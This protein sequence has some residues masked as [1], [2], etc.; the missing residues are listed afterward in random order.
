MSE[1]S[2]LPDQPMGVPVYDDGRLAVRYQRRLAHPPEK[3]WRALTESEHL[4][5]WMPCDIVGERRA[6]AAIELAFW[7]TAVE[8][9]EIEDPVLHGEIRVWDP[10]NVF[11]WSWDTDLLRWELEPDGEHTVLTFTTWFGETDPGVLSGAGA[12][13]HLCLDQ[14]IDLLDTGSV[15]DL[16]DAVVA[17]WVERYSE[18]VR[19][20]TP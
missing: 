12:G 9:Y 13:Y 14:L 1:Q 17:A 19:S 4:Q 3:V 2:T 20:A 16:D 5:H 6:G 15:A 18:A 8:R 7:P 10:P 11:E